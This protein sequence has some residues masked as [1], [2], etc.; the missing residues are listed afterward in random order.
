MVWHIDEKSVTLHPEF[1]SH[2]LKNMNFVR[3]NSTSLGLSSEP[4]I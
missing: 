4:T 3:P 1:K 2:K